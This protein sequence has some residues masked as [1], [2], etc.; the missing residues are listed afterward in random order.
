MTCLECDKKATWIRHTQFS[1]SHPYCTKHA[2]AQSDFRK[3]PDSYQDW[4]K[5]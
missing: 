5:I 3:E 4:Q 2:E 1:V